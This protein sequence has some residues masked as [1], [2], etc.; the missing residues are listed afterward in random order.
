M[1]F[2]NDI[3]LKVFEFFYKEYCTSNMATKKN[4]DYDSMKVT[5]LKELCKKRG[6]SASGLKGEIVKRLK[7]P[8]TK[9]ADTV[10]KTKSVASK[11]SKAK[12]ESEEEVAPPKKGKGKVSKKKV[13]EESEEESEEEVAPPKKAKGKVSKKKVV[14]E[15]EEESEEVAPPKKGKVSKKKVVEESEEESEEKESESEETPPPK[16]AKG[17]VSKKKVVEESEEEED[18]SEE[19]PPPKKGKTSQKK[20]VVEESEEESEEKE[21]EEDVSESEEKAPPKK[22]K[23]S[24][25]KKVVEESEEESEEKESEEKESEDVSESEE[26]APPKKSKGK[27]QKKVVEESEEESEEKESEED[28]SESEEKAPPKKSKGKSQK[29]VVEEEK[30]SEEDVSEEKAP[31]KKSKGK[32]SKSTQVKVSEEKTQASKPL[33]SHSLEQECIDPDVTAY[34]ISPKLLLFE[35]LNACNEVGGEKQVT[36]SENVLRKVFCVISEKLRRYGLGKEHSV[37][38]SSGRTLVTGFVKPK[39]AKPKTPKSKVQEEEEMTVIF[40]NDIGAYRLGDYVYDKKTSSVVGKLSGGDIVPLEKSDEHSFVEKSVRFTAV[41]TQEELD[42][43]L[44]ENKR[45]RSEEGPPEGED[46]GKE[47]ENGKEDAVLDVENG[48]RDMTTESRPEITEEKFRK[49][50]EAQSNGENKVDYVEISKSAGLTDMEGQEIMGNFM[51]YKNRYES[52]AT[53]VLMRKKHAP[54]TITS[55]KTEND[56]KPSGRRVIKK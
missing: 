38:Q 15:S 32:T 53:E 30:E 11:K 13:V 52:V 3:P 37:S 22:G 50:L 56:S 46:D 36:A 4:V 14:E 10:S 1:K 55:K 33:Q 44:G 35:A 29:K 23:T 7:A 21:S 8:A 27:S 2:L 48:V 9:K 40:D 24:Q 18:V 17:K 43:I 34:Y 49:F 16:K 25:K 39:S 6:I 31:P 26:K 51:A 54:S 12:E 45:M 41:K 19:T 42:S 28:V 5:E 47:I 20:K